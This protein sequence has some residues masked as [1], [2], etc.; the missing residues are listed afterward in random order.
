MKVRKFFNLAVNLPKPKVGG[1]GIKVDRLGSK[2]AP[3]EADFV[4]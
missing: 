4:I 1:S 2:T 3:I